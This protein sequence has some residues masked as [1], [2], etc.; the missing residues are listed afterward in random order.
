MRRR[1]IPLTLRRGD[2]VA[3]LA[4][5]IE[6]TGTAAVY[7]N[8]SCEPCA[9]RDEQRLA[10]PDIDIRRW[11]PELAGLPAAHIHAPWQHP[12]LDLHETR[13]RTLVDYRLFWERAKSR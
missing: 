6:E 1:G 8:R 11:I 9:R 10:N 5:L 4:E 13:R 7:C 3:V 12:C 2:A